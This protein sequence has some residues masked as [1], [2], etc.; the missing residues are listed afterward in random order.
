MG[1]FLPVVTSVTVQRYRY[2]ESFS[3]ER[4]GG[5]MNRDN[6]ESQWHLLEGDLLRT[7]S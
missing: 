5:S 4:I 3:S 1:S 6:G 2:V 7:T